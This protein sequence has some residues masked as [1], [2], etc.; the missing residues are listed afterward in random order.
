MIWSLKRFDKKNLPT[1]QKIKKL[2]LHTAT[3]KNKKF[4]KLKSKLLKHHDFLEMLFEMGVVFQRIKT[5]GPF[6]NTPK[7]A[8]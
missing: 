1:R 5:N 2:L 4:P 8:M 7:N 3:R 6:T